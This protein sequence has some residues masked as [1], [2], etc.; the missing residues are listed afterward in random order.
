MTKKLLTA[1]GVAAVFFAVM[2]QAVF[3]DVTKI[4]D[5]DHKSGKLGSFHALVI[6]IDAYNDGKIPAVKTASRGAADIAG[7]LKQNYGFHTQLL[8]NKKATKDAILG[9]IKAMGGKA[10]RNGLVMIYFAGQGLTSGNKGFWYPV[11]AKTGD[12]TSFVSN[13]SVQTLIA[14]MRARSVLLI[15]DGAYADTHFGSVHKLP[16]EITDGYYI[17]LHK[18]QSRWG[19]SSGN[20]SMRNRFTAQIVAALAAN[21]QALM[22]LQE[23]YE[24]VKP[25]IGAG[26]SR[27]PRCRSLRNAGDQG[28]EPVFVLVPSALKKLETKAELEAKKEGFLNI[29]VK[30]GGV[31]T[32]TVNVP[33]ALIFLDNAVLGKG[34]VV[35]IAVLP[36]NH[37]IEVKREGYEPYKKLVMV[38][39]EAQIPLVADLKKVVVKPTKG[40]LT[41]AVVPAQA[42]IK[43]L[44]LTTPYTPGMQ[45][46]NGDYTVEISAPY[47]EK[48][49]QEL[50]VKTAENNAYS[51]NLSPVKVIH[52]K[53]LGNFILVKPGKFSMGSPEKESS[54]RNANEKQ[55]QVTH[56]RPVYMQE[57]EMTVG[58]WRWFVKSASYKTEAEAG[59]GASVLVDYNW[60]KD[61]EYNWGIPGFT[62]NDK[63]PVTCVSWNDTQAFIKWINKAEKGVYTFRLPTEAE[64][65]YAC[66]AGTQTRFYSGDCL[67]R[68]QANFDGNAKWETCLVQ[69]S[70]KSTVETGK[71]S[72]N[73]WGLYDMHGN[74]ME[75]CQDW[76]GNYPDGEISDPVGPSAGTSKVVRGGGWTSYA[77]NSRSAKRFS[78]NPNES[79]SDLGFRLVIAP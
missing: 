8:L 41:V 3:C 40:T 17:G 18:K 46:E 63:H 7:V 1:M 53:S 66:R 35:K 47:Y 20:D 11:D 67:A 12:E 79:F 31:V 50:K 59:E 9:S 24:K 32:L 15:S 75:W 27:P 57:R 26:A 61:T 58:Q 19:F 54:L 69:E 23:L 78:R 76:F 6:G 42:E 74:V 45:L 64:W 62:Q 70:S 52:H 71:Y 60:E 10:G 5:M 72:P 55:H 38:K 43:F 25:G 36:G 2:A 16:A 4:E 28:G 68:A 77:Y 48:I 73:P 14:E 34:G 22:S 65:E 56:T 51:F 30:D 39:K 29:P 44:N 33:D 13:E 37:M 21:E 49:T